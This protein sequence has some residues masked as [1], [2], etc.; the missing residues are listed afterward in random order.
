MLIQY[1]CYEFYQDREATLGS[2]FPADEEIRN[3]KITE[4]P[5]QKRKRSSIQDVTKCVEYFYE[6]REKNR[7]QRRFPVYKSRQNS[8][9]L[10]MKVSYLVNFLQRR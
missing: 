7:S 2:V 5:Y 6:S 8:P 4:E 1:L 10:M 9:A 3:G